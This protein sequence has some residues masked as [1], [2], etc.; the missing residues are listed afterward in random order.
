MTRS[1]GVGAVIRHYF[2]HRF[3]DLRRLRIRCR[4]I[5]KINHTPTSPSKHQCLFRRRC[6][7]QA[8]M[9]CRKCRSMHTARCTRRRPVFPAH[10]KT[11]TM[12][13][14][15]ENCF[16]DLCIICC[17][18]SECYLMLRVT[19]IRH[20]LRHVYRVPDCMIPRLSRRLSCP[21]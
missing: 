3:Y 5:I 4:T 13:T 9:V 20:L 21:A 10:E 14:V 8:V 15:C 7:R 2:R 11:Q 17:F 12:D 16:H 1:A 18:L 6:C 19:R